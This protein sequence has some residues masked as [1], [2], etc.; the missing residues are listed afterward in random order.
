MLTLYLSRSSRVFVALNVLSIV[1]PQFN[2]GRVKDLL[3]SSVVCIRCF[4]LNGFL[5]TL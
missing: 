2:G 3:F 1:Y 5:E 4:I